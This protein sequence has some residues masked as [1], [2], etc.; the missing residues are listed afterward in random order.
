[1]DVAA[2]KQTLNSL[3]E[4]F[5]LR[6]F[7]IGLGVVVALY[8]LL[9]VWIGFAGS[10]YLQKRQ[11]SLSTITA[12]IAYPAAHQTKEEKLANQEE[13][14]A[15]TH[16][17]ADAYPVHKINNPFKAQGDI[18][19]ESGLIKAPAAQMTE[20]SPDGALPIIRAKDHLTPFD[21]YK[22]PFEVTDR[23][24]PYVSLAIADMGLSDMATESA[25]RTMPPQVS[26][27]MSPY[28]ANPDFWVNEARV[29]GHEIWMELPLEDKNYPN[30]DT[31]PETML[32]DAPERENVAKLQ[33]VMARFP[34]YIGFVTGRHPA[35][36]N[37]LH[38]MRPIVGDIFNRGLGFVDAGDQPSLTVASMAAGNKAPFSN[39]HIYI[40][41]DTPLDK[42]NVL[43]K[44]AEKVAKEKGWANIMIYPS[45]ASYQAVLDW[46]KTLENKG[47]ILA[48]LS[49]QMGH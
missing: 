39:I 35:F 22:R 11:D 38:D 42:V 14:A 43:L 49:A 10:G 40:P 45:P 28:A 47:I 9:F 18:T 15:K 6:P 2:T 7:L 46:L 24:K 12:V 21:A 20:E 4:K 37:S 17:S 48:P 5:E 1:M 29:R 8:L 26:L 36:L 31:G 16:E 19:L 34:G 27:V 32:I 23:A 44:Q 30:V 13:D 25:I 33:W 41:H 3:K